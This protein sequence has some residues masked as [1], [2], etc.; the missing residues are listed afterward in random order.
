M[1]FH[2]PF[3]VQNRFRLAIT[4]LSLIGW[5]L[6]IPPVF[7]PMGE[8]HR[9]FNDLSAPLA[10]GIFGLGSIPGPVARKKKNICGP[11]RRSALNSRASILIRI[12][13][14]T[15]WRF[16][17]HGSNRIASHPTTPA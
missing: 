17:K 13:T 7:S 15:P 8:H 6:L 16:R 12:P 2:G 3:G 1:G 14:A 10:N 4:H 11:K 5:Y 9:S